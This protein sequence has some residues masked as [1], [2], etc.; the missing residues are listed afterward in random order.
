[1]AREKGFKTVVAHSAEKSLP[2]VRDF[3]PAAITLDLRLP[4][5]DGWA[6]LDRWK[7]D[8]AT[9]HIPIHIISVEEQEERGLR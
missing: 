8:P 7:H 2:C 9:S 6:L 1:M 5:G 4:D 3:R